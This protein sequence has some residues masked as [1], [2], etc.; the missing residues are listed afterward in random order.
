MII[1]RHYKVRASLPP[2][3][4]SGSCYGKSL[5]SRG[6]LGCVP[7]RRIILVHTNTKTDPRGLIILCV[8]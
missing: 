6:F 3:N 1:T 7:F 2:E 4:T 5:H 8:Q